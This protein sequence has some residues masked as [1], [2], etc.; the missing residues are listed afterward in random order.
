[1]AATNRHT[2]PPPSSTQTQITA[3]TTRVAVAA[4]PVF[5]LPRPLPHLIPI[6]S[7][8]KV[9]TEHDKPTGYDRVRGYEIGLKDYELT[10]LDEAFT[11]EHWIV[12][13]FSVKKP[14]NRAER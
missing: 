3:L 4:A 2:Q 5:T 8:L 7:H 11:S 1:M 10:H 14:A 6:P 9:M 12:R 13:I